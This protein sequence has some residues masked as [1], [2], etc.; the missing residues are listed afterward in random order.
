[1]ESEQLRYSLTSLMKKVLYML[2]FSSKNKRLRDKCI[3]ELEIPNSIYSECIA[4][5]VSAQS[6]WNCRF[7]LAYI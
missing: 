5:V 6:F 2:G 3:L 1:M 7:L 4:P